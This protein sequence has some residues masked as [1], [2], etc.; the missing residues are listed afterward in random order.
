MAGEKFTGIITGRIIEVRFPFSGCVRSVSCQVGT[1]IKQGSL[2]AELTP[3]LLQKELDVQLADY[4][5]QRADFEI[6]SIKSKGSDD[7]TKYLKSAQQAKLNT[8]VKAVEVA[9]AKLDQA[10]LVSPV[11]GLVLDT[12]S[13]VVG[14]NITPSGFSIQ[15]LDFS[16][17]S[18][19]MDLPQDKLSVF[20]QPHQVRINIPNLGRQ[21]EG[22]SLLPLPNK[23]K[24]SVSVPLPVFEDLLTGMQGECELMS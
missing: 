4:E 21:L 7:I 10:K 5:Q 18:F 23:T 2:L 15:I 6:F 3:D 20:R 9:K 14:Q 8:S 16:G 13:M 1:L 24:F 22:V 12:S 19:Q 17:F 11:T